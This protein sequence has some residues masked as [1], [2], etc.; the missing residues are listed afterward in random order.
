MYLNGEELGK[1]M[2]ASKI[3]P[4]LLKERYGASQKV[5]SF[6]ELLSSKNLIIN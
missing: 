3:S 4:S 1:I 5:Q 2:L 6:Y